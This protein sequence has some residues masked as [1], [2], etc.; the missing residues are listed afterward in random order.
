MTSR[1]AAYTSYASLSESQKRVTKE[2]EEG[3]YGKAPKNCV[4]T[5]GTG[6]VGQRLVEMLAERGAKRVVCFDIVAAAENVSKHPAIEYVV[7][8]LRDAAAV[9]AA[10]KGA[11]CVWH[12]GAA[13]GP[14][15]PQELYKAV[16]V[17]G[18][19]NVIAAC[20]KHGVKKLVFSSSP[21]TRFG[22]TSETDPDGAT[23]DEMPV[24]PQATYVQ[25]YAKTKADAELMV[26]E[27]CDE[28]LMTIAVAPH[29]VYG[30]RDNLFLPNVLE[31]A[32]LGKLRVFGEGK[33]RIC[34]THVDNY[35]HALCLGEKVLTPGNPALGKF[36]IATDGDTHPH[37]E[38]Y[39]VFWEHIDSVITGVGFPSIEAKYHLPAWFIMFVG[40]L[41]QTMGSLLGFK[42]KLS[43]FSVRMLL[44]NRWFRIHN[45]ERDLG[46]KPV[47][48]F[49]EGWAD[50]ISWFKE[51]WLPHFGS[52]A[53]G[54]SGGVAQQ[55]QH[56]IDIQSRMGQ[57][58][59]SKAD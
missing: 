4:V 40:W 29:Q 26:R 42:P 19:A 56:K 50:T 17:D 34:F 31:V 39:C 21:S 33:N 38:G 22:P 35:A 11:D 49:T 47:I 14:Y 13:V 3:K 43:C 8:D 41:F 5:G 28:G 10:V 18:T 36:Y 48:G 1:L 12:N 20:R 53:S 59:T 58:D 54:L 27:A 45:I 52:G 24:I 37:P 23:E 16:N 32:G 6:F 44:M 25:E 2:G 51:Y 7:G 57:S 46:Y 55:T 15:H 30:P 9:E